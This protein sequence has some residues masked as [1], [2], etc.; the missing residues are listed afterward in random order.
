MTFEKQGGMIE[1]QDVIKFYAALLFDGKYACIGG[2][3][4]CFGHGASVEKAERFSRE[5]V[6]R[7]PDWTLDEIWTGVWSVLLHGFLRFVKDV[8]NEK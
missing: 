3:M 1:L 8:G 6:E 7:F 5:L 4:E 2:L